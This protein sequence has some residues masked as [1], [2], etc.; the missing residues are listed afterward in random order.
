GDA[1]TMTSG[2]PG[3]DD[4]RL[5]FTENN[6]TRELQAAGR[7]AGSA[8]ALKHLNPALAED[9]L[10]IAKELFDVTKGGGE[11]QRTAYDPGETAKDMTENMRIF[12]ACELFLS[13]GDAK[14]KEFILSSLP[15][16][17]SNIDEIGWCVCRCVHELQDA[18]FTAA[19]R[20]AAC[21]Y[22]EKLKELCSETPYGIPYRPHI[23]GAGWGIQEMA[24]CYYFIQKAF[25]DL[26]TKDLLF[27]SL[28]FVLGCHPGSNTASFASGIGAK[29]N[30]TAY[31][32]NRADWSFIPGGV[33]SGTALIRPDFPELLEFPFLWQQ[34]EYVIGG[35]ST[36]YMFLVLAVK[37]AL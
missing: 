11:T 37:N 18:A 1:S 6:P 14:Y 30:L 10:N 17:L 34:G 26:F 31:G 35:G 22:K 25:P 28:H 36:N 12:A 4:E 32:A 21:K 8:R 24:F 9:C 13:T 19:I 29:S 20:D 27:D 2:V 3:G 7:L 23:W 33:S 16:I 5:V 15:Y